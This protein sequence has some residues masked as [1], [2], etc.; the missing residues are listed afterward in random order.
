MK[1]SK[2]CSK[3]NDYRTLE[4]YAKDKR[5]SD[6]L[7]SECKIC[8]KQYRDNNRVLRLKKKYLYRERNREL[9][10][11]KQKLYYRDN[12]DS[13]M[14]YRRDNAEKIRNDWKAYY[15]ANEERLK[16]ATRVYFKTDKGRLVD[17]NCKSKRRK[18]KLA[19]MDGSIPQ[20]ISFPLTP[21]LQ[22]LL[23]EQKYKCK[24]CETKIHHKLRNIHLDHIHPL[25][26]G[27]THSLDNVQWLCATCNLTKSDK[28]HV[29]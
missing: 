18:L 6:G 3:C 19:T 16:S 27:G 5:A 8:E 13:I 21:E 12:K 26:K 28:L 17:I 10:S 22:E 25:S 1:T 15:N 29:A 14:K 23:E 11:E 4:N 7:K 20:N 2:T 9:L 24:Y